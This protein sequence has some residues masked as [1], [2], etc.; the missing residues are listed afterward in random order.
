MYDSGVGDEEGIF[1]FASQAALQF[2][3]DSEHWCA[4]DTFRICP[5]IFF[6][7]YTIHGQRD[8][9]IFPCV[10]SLLQNK[11]EN[12]YNRLFEQLFQLV[13]SIGDGPNDVLVKM[14]F[15]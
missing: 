15:W 4:D 13:N 10:F 1:A 11:N 6:Q 14:T 7:L 5:E 9:R 8:R 3:A 2:L 12:N